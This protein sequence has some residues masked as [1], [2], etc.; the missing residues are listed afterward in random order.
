MKRCLAY[1]SDVHRA[2][3]LYTYF[4]TYG[5]NHV[6]I[7]V[8]LLNAAQCVEKAVICM[9]SIHLY[10]Y[11]GGG[12]IQDQT[13]LNHHYGIGEIMAK[14]S[15]LFIYFSFP[16]QFAGSGGIYCIAFALFTLFCAKMTPLSQVSFLD[17]SI[18]QVP[19]ATRIIQFARTN[20]WPKWPITC[21]AGCNKLCEWLHYCQKPILSAYCTCKKVIM[22]IYLEITK[23]S[24]RLEKGIWK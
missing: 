13:N 23:A 16:Y 5:F 10:R 15:F 8:E 3:I 9:W 24:G 14:Y 4:V 18:F 2:L 20:A 17:Y 21:I 22:Q 7:G 1:F 6:F 11:W 19:G 12:R